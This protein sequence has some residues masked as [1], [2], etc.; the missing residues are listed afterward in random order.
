M[1]T[2]VVERIR[3]VEDPRKRAARAA[4]AMKRNAEETKALREVRD[5][6]VSELIGDGV[7]PAEVARVIGTSR[8]LVSKMYP[9]GE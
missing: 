5:D 2:R 7:R 3:E 6:A 9:P 1:A 4:A 8:A